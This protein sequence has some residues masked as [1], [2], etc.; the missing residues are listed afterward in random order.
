M[1]SPAALAIGCDVGGTEVK[2]AAVRGARIVHRGRCATP[3]GRPAREVIEAIADGARAAERAAGPAGARRPPGT[4]LGIAL[5]GLLDAR[6]A[7]PVHLSHLPALDGVPL[8]AVLG[9]RLGWPVVLDADSNA[10][11]YGEW[12]LGAGRR[13]RRLLYL[14]LGTGAGAAMV[15]GGEVVRVSNHTVGQ[16][17]HLPLDPSGPLCPCG[18][19]GCLEAVLSAGGILWRARRAA[20][21]RRTIPKA[22][23]ERVEIL[24]RIAGAGSAP[25]RRVLTETG[26]LLGRAL[27]ILANLL[28]PDRIVVGGGISGAGRLLLEPAALSLELGLIPRLRG[29][30]GLARARLGPHAGAVGAALLGRAAGDLDEKPIHEG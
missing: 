17:A 11:A 13:A 14:T 25:A 18:A 28:S 1:T 19:R 23:L 4:T 27:A 6:R 9:R 15:V 12:R 22:G 5:P 3:A 16:V 30:V 7:R 26:D 2:F 21:R 8:R 20:G 24:A 29:R 10:G